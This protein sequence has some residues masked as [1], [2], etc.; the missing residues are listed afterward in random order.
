[1]GGTLVEAMGW[2]AVFMNAAKAYKRSSRELPGFY[3]PSTPFVFPHLETQKE[4]LS[5]I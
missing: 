3:I 1:M 4:T 2:E 5:W